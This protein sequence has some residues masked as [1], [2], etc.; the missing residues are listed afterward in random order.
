MRSHLPSNTGFIVAFVLGVAIQACQLPNDE[1]N[2][3][4]AVADAPFSSVCSTLK[5]AKCTAKPTDLSIK[6]NEWEAG[7]DIF[8]EVLASPS[9]INLSRID[10]ERPA[11][12]HLF[13][14]FGAS[15]LM[16][17][18]NRV[19]WQALK[20]DLGSVV[21]ENSQV[22]QSLEV[23]GLKLIAA[24][25]V[26]L[27]PVD[28]RSFKVSGLSI[29]GASGAAQT[30][31]L[32]DLSPT[33]ALHIVTNTQRITNFPISFFSVDNL[34][35][36]ANLN[37]STVFTAISN[38]VLDAG[39]NWRK[40]ANLVITNANIAKINGVAKNAF[41]AGGSFSSAL[42]GVLPQA[43]NIIFGGSGDMV[44][45]ASLKAP[46]ACSMS[47]ANV[48]VLGSLNIGLNFG[49]GFG[50]NKLTRLSSGAVKGTIYGITTDIGVIQHIEIKGEELKIQV[51]AFTIP[52]SLKAQ[53]QGRGASLKSVT[54]R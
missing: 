4:A 29:A 28:K 38:V 35:Q 34:V 7:L 27:Q 16:A 43:K 12:K 10:L 9:R 30:V 53:A 52:L 47:F 18:V 21:L 33:G 25:K 20:T 26:V 54:C 2:I 36:P 32:I 19:P 13:A 40:N 50:L 8:R 17:F 15:G 39:F 14:T 24:Q 49:I 23:N 51:G 48:P 1:A 45:T 5:L 11:V 6:Q 41:P 37:A 44:L 22:T 42:D 46:L 3:H 31:A